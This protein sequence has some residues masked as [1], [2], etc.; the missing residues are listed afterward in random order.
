MDEAELSSL[1]P[2]SRVI[3]CVAA[4]QFILAGA[5]SPPDI[6]PTRPCKGSAKGEPSRPTL[7]DEGGGVLPAG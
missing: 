5:S 1:S 7:Q 6:R 2:R 3:G 4:V